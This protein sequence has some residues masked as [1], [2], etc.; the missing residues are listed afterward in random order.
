MTFALY[1]GATGGSPIWQ[2]A[3]LIAVADGVFNTLLGDVTPL[4][5]DFKTP[6]WL[7]VK[8][9]AAAEMTPRVK[10]TASG[11]SLNAQAVGGYEVRSSPTPNT[12]LPLNGSA[13]IFSLLL[14][15]RGAPR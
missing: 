5:L 1:N 8:V 2:E 13:K 11:Y 3:K 10:L 15:T 4:N 6:Y 9:G 12:L 7:G 14:Q